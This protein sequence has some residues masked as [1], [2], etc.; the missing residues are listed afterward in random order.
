MQNAE[1]AVRSA[2]PGAGYG[3]FQEGVKKVTV[4]KNGRGLNKLKLCPF[5]LEPFENCR[6]AIAI[7]KNQCP[8]SLESCFQK[9]SMGH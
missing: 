5:T 7:N 2:Y 1:Y 3:A 4:K 6:T 9:L 8:F